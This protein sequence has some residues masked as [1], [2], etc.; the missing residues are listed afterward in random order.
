M[1][2]ITSLFHQLHNGCREWSV[3][4]SFICDM[5]DNKKWFSFAIFRTELYDMMPSLHYQSLL[6]GKD[7]TM[8]NVVAM[9][10]VM[11]NTLLSASYTSTCMHA[12]TCI[13]EHASMYSWNC[14]QNLGSILNIRWLHMHACTAG[15]A[16]QVHA[17]FDVVK[18]KKTTELALINKKKV[19]TYSLH[20]K[21]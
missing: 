18:V 7:G 17:W 16:L 20:Y 8:P 1:Y 4:S 15:I 6:I 11:N 9:E 5:S 3:T 14:N 10:N 2:L 21:L 19:N 13:A 12:C